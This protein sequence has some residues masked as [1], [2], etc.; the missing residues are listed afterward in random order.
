MKRLSTYVGLFVLAAAPLAAEPPA[1]PGAGPAARAAE[2]RQDAKATPG[3]WTGYITDTHC[4]KKGATKDHTTAC[5][6][7]C[8]K[9]GSKAHIVNDADGAMY[10][11]DSEE[12]VKALVGRRV[13]IKGIL[14]PGTQTI[15]VES[16]A[17]AEK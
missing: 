7:K 8:I 17:V 14:Q 4:G 5:L 16:A 1:R 2:R 13:T 10:T 6:E 15:V 9:S 11:L 3:T 12:K